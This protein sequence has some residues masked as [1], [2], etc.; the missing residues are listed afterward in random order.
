MGLRGLVVGGL[1]LGVFGCGPPIKRIRIDPAPGDGVEHKQLQSFFL[2]G[3]IGHGQ[4]DVREICGPDRRA[5]EIGVG[6]DGLSTVLSV[7]TLGLYSP[8]RTTVQCASR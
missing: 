8:V 7:V 5:V 6:D 1:L 4:V 3:L 2:W